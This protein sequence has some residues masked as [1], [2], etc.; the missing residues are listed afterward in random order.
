MATAVAAIAAIGLFQSYALKPVWNVDLL[1]IESMAQSEG[2]GGVNC[3]CSLIYGSGC[4]ADNY[5]AS[6]NPSGT[7]DCWNYSRNCS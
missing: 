3:N 7:A 2:S 6:C 1:N 4:K 5:G